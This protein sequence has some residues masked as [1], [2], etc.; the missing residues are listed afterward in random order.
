MLQ[1]AFEKNRCWHEQILNWWSKLNTIHLHGVLTCA[2]DFGRT[3]SLAFFLLPPPQ[4][5]VQGVQSVH[6]VQTGHGLSLH[7]SVSTKSWLQGFPCWS[8]R[9]IHCLFLVLIPPPQDFEHSPHSDQGPGVGQVFLLQS[10]I[11]SSSPGQNNLIFSN[12]KLSG[13]THFLVLTFFD[14]I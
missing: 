10:S 1:V 2:S 4:L 12:P 9:L 3:H 14:E 8:L 5:T 7:F 11:T 6:S 13:R